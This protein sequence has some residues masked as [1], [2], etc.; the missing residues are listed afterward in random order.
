MFCTFFFLFLNTD[1]NVLLSWYFCSQSVNLVQAGYVLFFCFVLCVCVCVFYPRAHS[2]FPLC[3]H[4]SLKT[5]S[6]WSWLTQCYCG[7]CRVFTCTSVVNNVPDRS[8]NKTV[9]W[10]HADSVDGLC[11]W[12]E[13]HWI[14]TNL[15]YK[16]RHLDLNRKASVESIVVVSHKLAC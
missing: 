7:E 2:L 13:W 11:L 10:F 16:L 15:W 5:P 6:R 14:K 9:K 4:N 12:F 3:S 1:F 8:Q